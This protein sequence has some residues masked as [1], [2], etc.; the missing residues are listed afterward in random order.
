[1]PLRK[2]HPKSDPFE[3]L[4][5][6]ELKARAVRWLSMR[7]HTRI[8]LERKLHSISVDTEAI[9][10]VLDE[11]SRGG[12]Q[13]DERFAKTFGHYKAS[14]Q[15]ALLIAQSMRQ[16]GVPTHLID[17]TMAELASTELSR[18]R[19]V[20]DKKF[21]GQGPPASREQYAKQGR[22]LAGRGFNSDVIRRVLGQ[23]LEKDDDNG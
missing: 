20:W 22:F 21:G 12:W 19:L 16:K 5:A 7:E 2:P 13:S 11:L 6:S 17:Q 8:E 3:A 23:G 4:S 15:G 14:R 9:N 1:M 18:A 10:A